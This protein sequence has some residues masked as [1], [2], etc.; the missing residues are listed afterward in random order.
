MD[1]RASCEM[2]RH[3]SVSRV[4]LL[5]ISDDSRVGAGFLGAQPSVEEGR[6]QC[7]EVPSFVSWPSA[8]RARTHARCD[9]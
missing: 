9:G 7:W 1:G 6:E 5:V 2:A 8:E 3:S 4:P